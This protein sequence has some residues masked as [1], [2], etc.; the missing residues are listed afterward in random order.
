MYLVIVES[1]TKARTIK[2]ILGKEFIVVPTKGHVKDL[3]KNSL[4]VDE[5]TFKAH[6]IYLKGK[7]KLLKRLKELCKGCKEV[8]IATDPDREGE[9]MAHFIYEELKEVCPKVFRIRFYEI[10]K[11]GL[12]EALKNKGKIDLNLFRAYL[13]RRILDRLIGYKLSPKLW[14]EF[15]NNNLSTGRVQAPALS[16]IVE[17]EEEIRNFKVKKR[18]TLSL[19]LEGFNFLLDYSF[20]NPKD[21]KGLLERLRDCFFEVVEVL[22]GEERLYP[23]KP[24]ITSELI[25]V[26]NERLNYSPE[27]TTAIAQK[28]F[29]EGKITYPRTDSYRISDRFLGELL[30]FIERNFGREYLYMRKIK[31]PSKY[32]AHECIRPTK[33]KEYEEPLY[34]LI[35]KRTLGAFMSPAKLKVQKVVV[36]PLSEKLKNFKFFYRGKKITFDGFLR[37]YKV[38][39]EESPLMEVKV[40]QILKPKGLKVLERVSKPPSRYSEGSLIKKLE[41]LGIGRPSTYPTIL[42][43]LKRR[44]YVKLKG[45]LLYPTRL[46]E[47]VL[48]YLKENFKELTDYS[49]TKKMEELLDEVE[50]GKRDF[51]EVLRLLS[52]VYNK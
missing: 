36:S 49:F 34:G 1:P 26:A 20:E 29:E 22:E 48:K 51:R 32:S 50:E 47:E 40:G 12:K 18:Y 35:F 42:L 31:N 15:K 17:R 13:A 46:G 4:G 6:F 19:E 11:E 37:V 25:K 3:P 43:T 33:I 23:P 10:T 52:K 16:L 41:K 14:D 21:A 39:I 28:L 30:S 38:H 44:G 45:G 7:A 2:K 8:Y 24:F 5:K 27:R 9:G